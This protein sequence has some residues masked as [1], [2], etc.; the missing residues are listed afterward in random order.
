MN[1]IVAMGV[2]YWGWV[3]ASDL[4]KT[5]QSLALVIAMGVGVVFQSIVLF[6]ALIKDKGKKADD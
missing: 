2:G 4:L 5:D 3:L 6:P 1:H